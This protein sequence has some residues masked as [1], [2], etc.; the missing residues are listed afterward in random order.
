[1]YLNLKGAFH[2]FVCN[3]TQAISL[4]TNKQMWKAQLN[5]SQ[6]CHIP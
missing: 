6:K 5:F 1:M 4:H 2:R 3:L